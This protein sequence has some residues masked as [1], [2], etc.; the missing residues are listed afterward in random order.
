MSAIEGVSLK[1]IIQKMQELINIKTENEIK[2]SEYKSEY[3]GL[4]SFSFPKKKMID[5]RINENMQS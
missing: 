4:L 5:N 2:I 1:V 3:N